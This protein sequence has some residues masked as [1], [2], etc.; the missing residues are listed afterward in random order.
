VNIN[1]D[2]A[3]IIFDRHAAVSVNGNRD[4]VAVACQRF[5]D[6]VIDYFIN[7]VVQRLEVRSTDIHAGTATD[8]FQAFQYLDIFRSI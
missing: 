7:Q 6:R 2:A 5:V 8:G 1:R 3:P 4:A